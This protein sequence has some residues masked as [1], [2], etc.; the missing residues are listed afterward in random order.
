MG[1]LGFSSSLLH[2]S[3]ILFLQLFMHFFRHPHP[4]LALAYVQWADR[5]SERGGERRDEKRS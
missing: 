4:F 1:T 2:Y 5:P 3:N